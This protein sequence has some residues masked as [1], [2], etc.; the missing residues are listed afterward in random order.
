M[1]WAPDWLIY[2]AV[3]LAFLAAS[4]GRREQ[5]SAPTP[6]PPPPFAEQAPI[7]AAS[8]F[9]D[10]AL[11]RLRSGTLNRGTAFAASS[12]GVWLTARRVVAG[13]AK[14]ALMVADGWAAPA[15]VRALEGDVAVLT[16]KAG[17]PPLRFAA[18]AGP[19]AESGFLAGFSRGGPGEVAALYLGRERGRT[20]WAEV[21]RTDGLEG[22]L[23]GFAGAPVLNPSGLVAGMALADAPRR[24]RIAAAE[25]RALE[26]ALVAAK[27]R[28]AGAGAPQPITRDNYGRAADALRRATSVVA[29]ECL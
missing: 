5:V 23:F 6:P 1:R 26:A 16:T 17:A 10:T 14:P 9:A 27:A 25:P 13:C 20:A 19:R 24:G 21:G 4:I 15:K 11:V 12:Q 8:P 3:L 28:A 29:V 18:G 2:L 7:S 22:P